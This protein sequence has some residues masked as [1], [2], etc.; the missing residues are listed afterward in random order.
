MYTEMSADYSRITKYFMVLVSYIYSNKKFT[1]LHFF[2]VLKAT[3]YGNLATNQTWYLA[4][5][6]IT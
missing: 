5:T 3:R 4:P 6:K 1:F 2:E